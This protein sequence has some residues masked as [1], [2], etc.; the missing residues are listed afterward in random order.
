MNDPAIS[1][2]LIRSARR[3]LA[4]EVSRTGEVLVRAP[5]RLPE[6]EI[7][8]FLKNKKDWL[9]R[10]V[11]R[12]RLRPDHFS[13]TPEELADLR[14][15]AKEVLPAKVAYYSHLMGLVPTAVRI[16]SARTRF[17]SCSAKNSLNFSAYLMRFP[18]AA[19]DYVVVHEL[20]HIKHHNHSQAFYALI[21]AYLP[22]YKERIKLLKS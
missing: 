10:A 2:R 11:A 9:A 12:Q 20:A 6:A 16:T 4:I 14:K 18:E 19:I 7:L 17:G 13:A 1:Y 8:C 21:A 22:D 3:T 5:W 15:K